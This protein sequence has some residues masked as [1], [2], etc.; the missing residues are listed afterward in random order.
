MA[1]G[2]GSECGEEARAREGRVRV[3]WR[4]CVGKRGRGDKE[5]KRGGGD[6]E[7]PQQAVGAG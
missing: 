3:E 6:D 5:R 2:E 7:A 4:E 1:A